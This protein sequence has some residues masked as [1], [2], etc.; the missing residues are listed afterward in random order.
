MSADTVVADSFLV[1]HGRV[2]LLGA[3]ADR[4][5]RDAGAVGF[6]ADEARRAL[7]DLARSVPEAGRWFPRI[8]LLSDLTLRPLLRPAPPRGG[9]VRVATADHDPRTC[10]AV[11]GPD[12]AALS[13]Q[14]AR[15]QRSGADEALLLVDGLVCDG[16]LSAVVWWRD[17]VLHLPHPAL[18]RVDSVTTRWL[19]AQARV[20]G[21]E[22]RRV[23]ARPD[24]LAGAELWL[25]SALHG[26][27]PVVGWLDGPT[28]AMP[29]GHQRWWQQRLERA[30]EPVSSLA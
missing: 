4:F 13:E 15:A 22:V 21:V 10:P 1:D 7:L 17:D 25:L 5:A 26:I 16:A 20:R 11:K 14:R 6:P 23:R 8:D 24:D 18:A 3:H 9:E 27:R 2:L 12:L 28:V 19:V 29:G 30:R